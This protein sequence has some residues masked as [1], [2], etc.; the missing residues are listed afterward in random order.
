MSVWEWLRSFR[1]RPVDRTAEARAALER[2]EAMD[3]RVSDLGQRL[4]KI[5]DANGFSLMVAD[6]I[7]RS[8]RDR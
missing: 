1:H 7:S 5:R 8:S 2:L 4:V 6:A 3:A